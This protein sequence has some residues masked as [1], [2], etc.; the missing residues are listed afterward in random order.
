MSIQRYV[1]DPYLIPDRSYVARI[2]AVRQKAKDGR[3]WTVASLARRRSRSRKSR[4]S[5]LSRPQGSAPFVG[6]RRGS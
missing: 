5:G 3:W 1:Q 4:K 6:D 2:K